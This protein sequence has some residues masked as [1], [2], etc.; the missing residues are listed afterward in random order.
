MYV[1]IITEN[2][3]LGRVRFAVQ[4]LSLCELELIQESLITYK[5]T[6]LQDAEVFKDDRRDCI[7]MYEKIDT[8]L[9]RSRS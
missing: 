6:K 4:D 7:E 8:E 1:E 3:D 5:Q 9:I 2:K